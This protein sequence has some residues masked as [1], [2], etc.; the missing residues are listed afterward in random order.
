MKDALYSLMGMLN[1]DER[2]IENMSKG[3]R[4]K[5]ADTLD[6]INVRIPLGMYLPEALDTLLKP[7]GLGWYVKHRNDNGEV[8]RNIEVYKRGEGKEVEIL[9]QTVGSNL[10]AGQSQLEEAIIKVVTGDSVNKVT[11]MGEYQEVQ[12]SQELYRGWPTSQDKAS[13]ESLRISTE[14]TQFNPAVWRLWVANEAGDWNEYRTTDIFGPTDIPD[15]PRYMGDKFAIE[16]DENYGEATYIARRRQII[17][18]LTLTN[19]EMRR[20]PI[21]LEWYNPH[22][23]LWSTVPPEWGWRPLQDQIGVEFTGDIPPEQLV[24]SN[25]P[26]NDMH[27]KLRMIYTFQADRRIMHTETQETERINHVD[28]EIVLNA[29]D[30][31]YLRTIDEDYDSVTF[32]D[33]EPADT[34]DD[35]EAIEDYTKKILKNENTAQIDATFKLFGIR[36][37]YEIGQIIKGIK[38]RGINLNTVRSEEKK[39]LQIFR[40][41]YINKID[42]LATIIHATSVRGEA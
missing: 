2:Y 29:R 35:R 12:L 13:L 42:A 6:L 8:K 41:E 36:T 9:L 37:E 22:S 38:G 14:A 11:V 20:A 32:P 23:N 5:L 17:E 15:S 1:R 10:V 24:A 30:Q 18:P 27:V 40:I 21:T 31:F 16:D 7:R 33:P 26:D 28:H 34:A 3:A 4:N 25:D 19:T 39:Y